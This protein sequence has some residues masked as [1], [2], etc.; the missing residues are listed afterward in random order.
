M[1]DNILS[2][3]NGFLVF[4]NHCHMP[5][6]SL[7]AVPRSSSPF[8]GYGNVITLILICALNANFLFS[9]MHDQQRCVEILAFCLTSIVFLIRTFKGE[10]PVLTTSVVILLLAFLT[11]GAISASFA[12]SLHYAV[13]EWSVIL[14]SLML[15]F[16]VASELMRDMCRLPV[17]LHWVGIACVLYSLRALLMYAMALASGFQLDMHSLAA[18]F[19]N[20]RHLNH[21][22]TALLPLLVLLSLRAPKSSG[23]RKAWFA[24]A[25]F[26]WALLFVCEAR[27]SV[28]ALFLGC[29]TAFALRRSNALPFIAMMARTALL[30][31]VLYAM[32]FLMFPILAGL[33]PISMPLNVVARTAADPTSARNLLWKLAFELIAAHPWLGVGPQHFAHEGASLYAAAHPHN[34]M[35]QIGAEW[36][37]PALFCLSG[38]V[39]LGARGLV[40]SGARIADGDR[41]NQEILVALLVACTAIFVD[42][43][44]SGVIVMPQSQL[45]ITLVLG[46]A[47]AWVRLQQSD[48][49]P[50]GPVSTVLTRTFIIALV[51]I[52]LSGLMWSV[53]PDFVARARGDAL[54]PAE[55]A[56]NP[57]VHWPRMW[58][59]G[60][61]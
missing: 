47:C 23:W 7:A 3:S 17:L 61:F 5:S 51:T 52:G 55:L 13:S 57:T 53:A 24:V 39:F 18:G 9:A 19:S 35:L 60:Y 6:F 36:G 58:E 4:F 20:A 12:N 2:S 56:K 25:A 41:A 16:G 32:L 14:L 33:Q 59:A 27:A 45:A 49:Q 1:N 30:G 40:R 31:T 50:S 42:G 22:Q 29:V 10:I 28:V 43:L 37:V 26:W 38:A 8:F 21:T 46:I 48:A 15:V 11:L 34:W 54:T 44:L